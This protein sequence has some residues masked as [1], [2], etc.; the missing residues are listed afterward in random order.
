MALLVGALDTLIEALSADQISGIVIFGS[1]AISLNGID[2]G[3]PP[4]D[5]DIF[6]SDEAFSQLKRLFPER[7]KTAPDGAVPYLVPCPFVEILKTFPGVSFE[8]VAKR[9][10]KRPNSKGILVGSLVDLI[11]W[12]NSQ[13]REKDSADLDQISQQ[14]FLMS[15]PKAMGPR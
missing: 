5:I 11:I 6:V 13:G 4:N 10:K 8:A 9:A 1:A 12:K 15:Q 7:I 2:L 3:R 14:L